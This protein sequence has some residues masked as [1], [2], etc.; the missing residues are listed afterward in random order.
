MEGSF[1]HGRLYYRC[2]ASRDFV[3]Q[4]KISHPPCLYLREETIAGQI[5]RFLHQALGVASLPGTLRELAEAQ[6]RAV[7]VLEDAEERAAT[8]RRTLT[9]CDTKIKNYR[10]ALDAGGDPVLIAGWIKETTALRNA[11][12][13]MIGAQ[14]PKSARMTEDQIGEIVEGLG[15]LLGLLRGADPADRAEVYARI[16]LRLTYRPGPETVIAEVIS[17]AINGVDDV[18]PRGDLNP[19]VWHTCTKQVCMRRS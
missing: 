2:A 6:H 5:D 17:P 8:L 18:C 3:R 4:H 9:D 10:A 11:T 19:H 7:D 16:G 1:N 12:Q 13:A 15:G 14:R